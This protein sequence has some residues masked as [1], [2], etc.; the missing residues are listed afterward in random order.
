MMYEWFQLDKIHFSWAAV[1]QNIVIFYS[2][3]EIVLPD[4]I[5]FSA[6]DTMLCVI[7]HSGS[8][9]AGVF[10]TITVCLE[11]NVQ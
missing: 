8:F 11:F 10:S 1:F 5:A 3:L 6:A 2:M 7:S 9:T 4:W